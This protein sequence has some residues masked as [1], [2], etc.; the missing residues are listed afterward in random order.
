MGGIWGQAL[1][2]S[3]FGESHGDAIG[4]VVD[5]LPAGLPIDKE[6]IAIGMA[7]R[8]PGKDLTSTPRKERDAVKIVSGVWQ[9]HS[10][11]APICGIIENTNTRSDDYSEMQTL[12]RPSH[13][14]YT[15][16]VRYDGWNDIRGGGHFSGRLTAPLVFA[17]A[18]ARQYLAGLGVTVGAHIASIA[19]IADSSFDSVHMDG[20]QLE[21]VSSLP[22]PL[23]DSAKES[24]MRECIEEARMNCDSVGGVIECAAVGVPAGWGNPFFDSLESSV[25]HLLFSIPAVKAVSFG[26]GFALT[27]MRGSQANDPFYM[28]QG[29]VHTQSNHNGGINGGISNGMPILL[30]AAIKPTASIAQSQDTIDYKTNTDAKLEVRGR[31]DPCIVIRAVPVVEAA[32]LLGLA[33]AALQR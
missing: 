29:Q 30:Q 16:F 12:A 31:H 9:G 18:L 11:G 14:D 17:G 5:G 23:L 20:K 2:L 10:T 28:D 24:A 22:F 33:D 8:A 7:R 19:Q 27:T 1:R 4:M 3:I 32:L 26:D 25:S 21:T 15:G 13:A 6:K